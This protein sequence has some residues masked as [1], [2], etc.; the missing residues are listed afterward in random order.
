LHTDRVGSPMRRQEGQWHSRQIS[1]SG[2][3]PYF[4]KVP[5]TP[6]AERKIASVMGRLAGNTDPECD[7][8]T[9]CHYVLCSN[10]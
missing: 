9:V 2:Y 10:S 4:R 6:Q 8:E 5:P 7:D 3:H 1:Q